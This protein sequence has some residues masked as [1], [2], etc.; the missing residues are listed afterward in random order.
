VPEIETW[1]FHG[2]DVGLIANVGTAGDGTVNEADTVSP[3][4]VFTVTA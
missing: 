2:P 4:F 3:A 1:V